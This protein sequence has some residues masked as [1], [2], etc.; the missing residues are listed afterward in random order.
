MIGLGAPPA[1]V[2]VALLIGWMT[3]PGRV[4]I[5]DVY[6]EI[7]L[8]LGWIDPGSYIGPHF[9]AVATSPDGR[10]LAAGGMSPEV[11]MYD[12]Q[13]GDRLAPPATHRDWVMEVGWSPDMRW[14]ASSSFGGKVVVQRWPSLEVVGTYSAP[15]V[16][17]TFDFHPTQPL[18]AWGAHDGQVRLV[19]LTTGQQTAS[20]STNVG[21]VLYTAFTPDGHALVS[22]G[23]DGV[24][25]FHD[26][27]SGD[28]VASWTA[29]GAG[30]TSVAFSPDGAL[31]ATGGDDAA[32]RL[33][34]TAT[35][36][37]KQESSPHRG[38]INFSVFLPD[39]ERW[40]SVG[41]DD[42]VFVWTVGEDEP[43]ALE[44]HPGW[45]MCARPLPDGSGFVTSGKDGTIRIWDAS[46]LEVTRTLSV[47]DEID[48]GGWRWPAL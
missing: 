8:A 37:L 13:T 16:A 9:W 21:G 40:L 44:G 23:E 34:E 22:G 15:E 46:T 39:G 27:A 14:F 45:L 29:H 25:Y 42:R 47:F 32:V 7:V 10:Y 3:V 35:A 2:F 48:P 30:I 38:W 28:Q 36:T 17:Y 26:L 6:W 18:F 4:K 19:D 41:T 20:I 11:L 24:V 33:W 5:A 43:R 1:V 31:V 12:L